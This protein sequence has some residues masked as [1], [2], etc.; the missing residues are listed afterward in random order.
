MSRLKVF[1]VILIL[2]GTLGLVYSQFSYTGG[3]WYSGGIGI[4]ISNR[5][6]AI[7]IWGAVAAIAIGSLILLAHHKPTY[8]S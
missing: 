4:S 3:A 8:R 6:V 2:V 7:P 5:S 1:A